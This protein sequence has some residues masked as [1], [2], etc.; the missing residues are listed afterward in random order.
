MRC[1][2]ECCSYQHSQDKYGSNMITSR[3][4]NVVATSRYSIAETC[5][6]LRIHRNT[7][8]R[9]TEQGLIRQDETRLRKC[10]KGTEILRFWCRG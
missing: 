6:I 3:R 4:P 9:Y 7:L 5:N 1:W 10:Y 2:Q 8:R